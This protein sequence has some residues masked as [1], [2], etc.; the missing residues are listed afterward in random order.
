MLT[1]F[2]VLG[3]HHSIPHLPSSSSSVG[4]WVQFSSMCWHWRHLLSDCWSCQKRSKRDLY[5]S[6]E[7]VLDR[8]V[9]LVCDWTSLQNI[10]LFWR[11]DVQL[12]G[13]CVF[14]LSNLY[15]H[16]TLSDQ[17]KV[18]KGWQRANNHVNLIHIWFHTLTVWQRVWPLGL[19]EDLLCHHINVNIS[20]LLLL[21]LS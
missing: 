8:W 1:D 18:K 14:I 19:L 17:K 2:Q 16:L 12:S 15:R 20:L 9:A 7:N 5:H 21:R 10:V 6:L 11:P 13:T 4:I 3:L